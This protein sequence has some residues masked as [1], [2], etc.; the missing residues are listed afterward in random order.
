MNKRQV[1]KNVTKAISNT[2]KI[3]LLHTKLIKEYAR[4]D[5]VATEAKALEFALKEAHREYTNLLNANGKLADKSI[6][7]AQ[8]NALLEQENRQLQEDRRYL[9]EKNKKQAEQI[10][11]LEFRNKRYLEQLEEIGKKPWYKKIFKES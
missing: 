11:E 7:L 2:K 1:K 6:E 5:Q 3:K 8:E 10:T 4:A 9:L